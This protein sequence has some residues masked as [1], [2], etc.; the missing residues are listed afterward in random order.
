MCTLALYTAAFVTIGGTN[1][2]KENTPTESNFVYNACK[3]EGKQTSNFFGT[4]DRC[5]KELTD[6]LVSKEAKTIFMN[7]TSD[8]AVIEEGL[9]D[10]DFAKKI[11]YVACG[12]FGIG[13][14]I[15][16]IDSSRQT[17]FKKDLLNSRKEEI[18]DLKQKLAKHEP[19]NKEYKI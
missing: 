17:R 6:H 2:Y 1:L 14:I 8:K 12:L 18:T 3:N 16:L 19:D 11:D 13:L 4:E 5:R 15:S 7:S 10:L 9:E